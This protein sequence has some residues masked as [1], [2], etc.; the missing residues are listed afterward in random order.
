LPAFSHAVH[1]ELAGIKEAESAVGAFNV[2]ARLWN[3]EP[4]TAFTGSPVLRGLKQLARQKDLRLLK[5]QGNLKTL[6]R[7]DTPALLEFRMPG[8]GESRFFALTGTFGNR[9]LIEPSLLG[10]NSFT[11]EELKSIWSG[12]AYLLWK[13]FRKIPVMIK[14]AV[15]GPTVVDLQRLLGLN[16]FYK[17]KQTGMFDAATVKA[18]KAFQA[19]KGISLDGRVGG[20]TLL[21]LYREDGQVT[22]PR[23]TRKE[24]GNQG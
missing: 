21:L 17:G 3:V 6:L 22:V 24:G 4:A 9:W 23:L 16:G 8:S 1:R 5:I 2:L 12:R 14:P 20:L 15:K 13:N 11:A 10:R 19:A 18:V 7:L